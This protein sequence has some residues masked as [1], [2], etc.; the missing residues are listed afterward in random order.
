MIR[1]TKKF[2]AWGALWILALAFCGHGCKRSADPG[3][4][5]PE[6]AQGAGTA[7]AEKETAQDVRTEPQTYE[8]NA[9]DLLAARLPADESS[10]GWIRLFDGHTLFGWEITGA[11]NWRVEEGS[12]V[13]DKGANCLLCT[14]IPWQDYEL[15]LE[16][17]AE[18]KTNSGVF[19]RSP[20]APEDP[21][22]DCYEV[23]IAP[24]DHPF[25]TASVVKRKKADES[26]TPQVFGQWRTMNMHLEGKQLR[27]TV[28]NELVCDYTDPL[29]LSAGRIGLQH[30]SGR[31]EFR[32]IR[33]RPLGLESL[34]DADLSS[35][36]KYPEMPGEFTT[37]EQGWLR[38]KGGRTQLESKEPYDDFVLL[39]EYKLPTVE[40]NSG[41]FFRCIPG[42][43]MM[44]YECQLSNA[45]KDNNPLSPMDCGSGGIFRRQ[46]ARIVAGEVDKWATV[47]LVAHQEMMSAWVNGVQVSNWFDDRPP[48][49]NPRE[50]RRLDAGT[51]M[52]QGHDPGTDALLKQ[53]KIVKINQP[54]TGE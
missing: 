37:T 31:I 39:A 14:S 49:E 8:A 36:N 10:M 24:G 18:E 53:I 20:L 35:W 30:N 34:L 32:D 25:P 13:V 51:I 23:N 45:M 50:G 44:G 15:T 33:L 9:D 48:H 7:V 41:I 11:A 27:V 28:D 1:Q 29:G 17:K 47:L 21:A 43:V 38:V 3:N 12:I 22:I 5:G 54:P 46:D 4:V 16:F 6:R 52:I 2:V 40:M 42:D 19:L 26:E